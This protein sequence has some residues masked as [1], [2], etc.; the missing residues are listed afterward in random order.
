[1]L[2]SDRLQLLQL[3]PK[4]SDLLLI[5]FELIFVLEENSLQLVHFRRKISLIIVQFG[6]SL[7]CLI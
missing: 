7:M 1:M 6:N 3:I 4:V 2:V 5:Q